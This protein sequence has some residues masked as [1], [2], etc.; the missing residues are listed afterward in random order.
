MRI[1]SF[2]LLTIDTATSVMHTLMLEPKQVPPNKRIAAY[3]EDTNGLFY[4]TE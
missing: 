2:D 3:Q 1:K 4:P